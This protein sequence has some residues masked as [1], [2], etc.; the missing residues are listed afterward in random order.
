ME[1]LLSH[2]YLLWLFGGTFSSVLNL[3]HRVLVGIHQFFRVSTNTWYSHDEH[4][5][6]DFFSSISSTLSISKTAQLN[7]SLNII[8]SLA[9]SSR[10]QMCRGSIFT[11]LITYEFLFTEMN[12]TSTFESIFLLFAAI[13]STF[14]TYFVSSR[15]PAL[16]SQ[17]VIFTEILF[18]YFLRVSRSEK[19]HDRCSLLC[20]ADDDCK[21]FCLSIYLLRNCVIIMRLFF[22][23][24]RYIKDFLTSF[25]IPVSET[26][27]VQLY[28]KKKVTVLLNQLRS[29][30]FCY[31]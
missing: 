10:I 20:D 29:I 27:S 21:W 12:T 2:Y 4:W 7:S 30:I 16:P 9:R 15:T 26:S 17:I 1:M 28:E 5:I 25:V 18:T 31:L 3:N 23:W 11:L 19:S 8:L 13:I 24:E 14:V 6:D 22:I